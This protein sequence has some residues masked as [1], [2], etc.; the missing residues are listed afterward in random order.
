MPTETEDPLAG[1]IEVGSVWTNEGNSYVVWDVQV[2][3]D[4]VV[5][6]TFE[7]L[8]ESDKLSLTLG[9]VLDSD[10]QFEKSAWD[11][12]SEIDWIPRRRGWI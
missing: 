2:T 7:Q 8:D 9:D 12:R 10:M 1:A 6:I 5:Q 4:A 11:A 3:E